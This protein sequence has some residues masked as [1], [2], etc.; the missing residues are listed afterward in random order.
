MLPDVDAD[1]G[2]KRQERVLVRGRRELEALRRRVVSLFPIS[3]LSVAKSRRSA[4][5]EPAPA[6]ALNARGGSVEL[7]DEGVERTPL[8][9]DRVGERA[10]L[11]LATVA[12]ALLSRAGKVLPEEGVVDVSCGREGE[13]R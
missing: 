5:H 11:E 1:D 6:G 2:H 12:L 7:L 9:V 4:T 10:R 8:L 3:E 13:Q